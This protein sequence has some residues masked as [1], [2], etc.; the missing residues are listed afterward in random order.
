MEFGTAGLGTE[1]RVMR[2]QLRGHVP[3]N[4]ITVS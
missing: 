1:E 4:D 2:A 3:T